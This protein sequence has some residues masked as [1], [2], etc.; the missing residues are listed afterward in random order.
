V[1]WNGEASVNSK[2]ESSTAS[3]ASDCGTVSLSVSSSGGSV[4][5]A[6]FSC[7]TVI[8]SPTMSSRLRELGDSASRR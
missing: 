8:V 6:S 3:T 2:V 4:S 1:Y 7:S 5:E